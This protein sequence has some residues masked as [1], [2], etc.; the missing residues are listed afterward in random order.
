MLFFKSSEAG[1]LLFARFFL[2]VNFFFS[3][4]ILASV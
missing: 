4:K 3:L 2:R 1:K